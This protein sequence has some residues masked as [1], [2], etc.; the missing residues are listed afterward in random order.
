MLCM[1]HISSCATVEDEH[2]D[3][4]L[5]RILALETEIEQTM[6]MHLESSDP[7]ISQKLADLMV[8]RVQEYWAWGR[9]EDRKRKPTSSE[10]K[11]ISTVVKMRTSKPILSII[12]CFDK[13]AVVDT[14][15]IRGPLDG[16]GTTFF[17][18]KEN[19]VWKIS[20]QNGWVS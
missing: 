13:R 14:G 5:K 12:I 11:A 1:V 18:I 9:D 6:T 7:E 17:L 8:K 15:V 3:R 2:E 4:Y 19:G 10:L 20:F 16:G